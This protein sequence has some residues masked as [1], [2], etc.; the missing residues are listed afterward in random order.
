MTSDTETTL[1]CFE[2]DVEQVEADSHDGM[3]VTSGIT[4][5][6]V[7]PDPDEVIATWQRQ[8]SAI[9]SVGR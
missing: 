3:P 9:R 7:D 5:A 1:D 2:F 6:V 4:F 8:L